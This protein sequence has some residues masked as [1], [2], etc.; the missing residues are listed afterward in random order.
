VILADTSA[1]V[2]FDR[3]TGSRVDERMVD[4]ITE[5]ERLAV[6]EPVMAEVLIGARGEGDERALRRMLAGFDLLPFEPSDFDAAVRIHRRCRGTGVTLR[7]IL[8]CTIAAVAWRTGA[9]L[10]ANDADIAR[11]ATVWEIDLDDASLHP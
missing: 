1:W 9:T 2:E 3:A 6:T 7:G 11:V 10:L 8:D 5:G 4:L